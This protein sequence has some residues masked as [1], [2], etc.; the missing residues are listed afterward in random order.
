MTSC[1]TRSPEE[2]RGGFR[3]LDAVGAHS[4]S[5][6][7]RGAGTSTGAKSPEAHAPFDRDWVVV[8]NLKLCGDPVRRRS[9]V[10][11]GGQL[12]RHDDALGHLPD[13][14]GFGSGADRP[15]PSLEALAPF[16]ETDASTDLPLVAPQHLSG[17]ETADG[18]RAFH[19]A[20]GAREPTASCRAGHDEERS[21][22][23]SDQVGLQRS[24]SLSE[25]GSRPSIPGVSVRH[26][27]IMADRAIDREPN[28]FP[29]RRLPQEPL[30]PSRPRAMRMS[31]VLPRSKR[32]RAWPTYDLRQPSTAV[33]KAWPDPSSRCTISQSPSV[34]VIAKV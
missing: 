6:A 24:Q 31:S 33:P 25:R 30:H 34:A 16:V 7:G 2:D 22:T 15:E 20:T 21:A 14:Q 29:T 28:T 17:E 32:E 18:A 4:G 3:W 9:V 23:H 13:L 8:L 26:R 19:V 27:Q 12:H 11:L 10:L 5:P 1:R